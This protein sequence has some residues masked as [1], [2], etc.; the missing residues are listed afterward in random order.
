[1]ATCFC[2]QPC[3]KHKFPVIRTKEEYL[4]LAK[5]LGLIKDKK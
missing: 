1:M 4:K 5:E 3:A 2:K